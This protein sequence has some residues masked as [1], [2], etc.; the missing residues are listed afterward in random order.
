M[1]VLLEDVRPA[2]AAAVLDAGLVGDIETFL[3]AAISSLTP[4]RLNRP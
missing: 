1:P 3:Q 4:P 2:A